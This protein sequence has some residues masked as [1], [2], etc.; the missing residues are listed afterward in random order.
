[1]S[2]GPTLIPS[3]IVSHCVV[4]DLVPIVDMYMLDTVRPM[5]PE[6]HPSNI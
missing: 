2:F 4:T 1:M 3:I 5:G 6:I